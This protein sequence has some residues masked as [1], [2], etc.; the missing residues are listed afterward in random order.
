LRDASGV[1]VEFVELGNECR[2]EALAGFDALILLLARFT[3][4]SVPQD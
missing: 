1:E 4:A 3:R 2:P